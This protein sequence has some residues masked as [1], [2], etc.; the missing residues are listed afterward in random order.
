M[1]VPKPK[2]LGIILPRLLLDILI[3]DFA[4]WASYNMTSRQGGAD[5][6]KAQVS[7]QVGTYYLLPDTSYVSYGTS[8]FLIKTL[9]YKSK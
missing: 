1:L 8:V 9:S 2:Y 5:T 3:C 7:T 6:R 4:K